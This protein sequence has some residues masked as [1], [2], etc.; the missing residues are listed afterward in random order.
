MNN[1]NI[2]KEMKYIIDK[3][4]FDELIV[5]LSEYLV[6]SDFFKQ[7]IHNIY[8]D[9]DHN[10]IIMKSK[11]SKNF[12]EKLRIRTYEHD[13][14]MVND[15]YIELKKK[16]NGITYKRRIKT[17]NV[18]VKQMFDDDLLLPIVDD[19]QI[20]SEVLHFINKNQCRPKLYLSY[21]RTA[22]VCKDESDMR[23]TFDSNILTRRKNLSLGTNDD[24]ILY[25]DNKFVIMEVKVNGSFPLWFVDA[26]NNHGLCPTSYSKYATILASGIL[27]VEHLDDDYYN[28]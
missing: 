25:A 18:A 11:E 23:I 1:G 28:M 12:K 16:Y 8:Y 19:S 4:M 2:R 5:D 3:E 6:P 26:L 14:V 13:G 7:R 27:S 24:D 9:N 21:Y 10:G 15:A 20:K 22:Y 17:T